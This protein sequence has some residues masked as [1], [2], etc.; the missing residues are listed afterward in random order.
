MMKNI[1]FPNIFRNPRIARNA[2]SI[3]NPVEK[4]GDKISNQNADQN[5][6][7]HINIYTVNSQLYLEI[8]PCEDEI[9][10]FQYINKDDKIG[11]YTQKL[12]DLSISICV[13]LFEKINELRNL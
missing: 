6:T 9:V 2:V 11:P 1:R 12:I 13:P 8:L 7:K 3:F 5:M 4:T 10:L